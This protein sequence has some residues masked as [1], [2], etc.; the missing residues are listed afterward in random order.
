MGNYGDQSSVEGIEKYR[1][2]HVTN[3]KPTTTVEELQAFLGK[4]WANVRCEL[5]KSK[6]PESY[7]SF[8]VLI[9][10]NE[11]SKVFVSNNWPNRAFFQ[12]RAPF[13]KPN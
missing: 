3:L 12:P 6:Y 9:K 11:N 13:L 8:E 4:N 10:E 1:A 2:F 5:V 7:A